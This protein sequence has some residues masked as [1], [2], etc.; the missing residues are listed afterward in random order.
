MSLALRASV[1]A[2]ALAAGC[3]E[4]P[5][6]KVA[7]PAPPSSE[8]RPLQAFDSIG[9]PAAR[10]RA[11]FLEASRVMLSPRC[12]NCHP[13]GDAPTQRDSFERHDPPVLRG[14]HDQGVAGLECTSCHQ[15]RNAEL[16]RVPGAPKWQLAPREMA[17]FGKTPRVLCEQLKDPE[18]NGH[19][20]LQ[21]VVDHATHD[22]IV[23]W[24]WN[25]GADRQAVP[26]TQAQFGELVAGWVRDGAACPLSDE[27][28]GR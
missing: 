2:W 3:A 1:L 13:A 12:V 16:A 14:D 18:R 10:S 6:P 8:L 27:E 28:T 21:A 23:A 25:P 7:P 20:T 9:D 11:I 19:R 5:P 17:W 22:A 26:G 15:D 24:G 4:P